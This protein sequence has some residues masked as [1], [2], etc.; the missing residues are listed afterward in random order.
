MRRLALL[1][2]ALVL[3]LGLFSTAASGWVRS[4][5]FDGNL[6]YGPATP[7]LGMPGWSLELSN[8]EIR[9]G[10]K[11]GPT[12]DRR[13]CT[14]IS[15]SGGSSDSKAK[16]RSDNG[17]WTLDPTKPVSTYWS[18]F[19]LGDTDSATASPKCPQ[20]RIRLG[21][22]GVTISYDART[23]DGSDIRGWICTEGAVTAGGSGLGGGKMGMPMEPGQWHTLRVTMDPVTGTWD[24][25][26]DDGSSAATHFSGTTASAS[27]SNVYLQWGK[28]DSS[29]AAKVFCTEYFYWGQGDNLQNAEISPIGSAGMGV[30]QISVNP[31]GTSATV[32]WGTDNPTT[33]TVYWGKDFYSWINSANLPSN[34]SHSY[35]I[36]NLD[37]RTTYSVYC[38]SSDGTSTWASGVQQFRSADTVTSTL[39]NSGFE[40]GNDFWP[41]EDAV[42]ASDG[43][44]R[45]GGSWYD[46]GTLAMTGQM[47]SGSA[48]D[49][50]DGRNWGCLRQQVNVTPGKAYKATV[51]FWDNFIPSGA[52]WAYSDVEGRIGIDPTGGTNPGSWISN[53]F[54][55]GFTDAGSVYWGNWVY[56]PSIESGWQQASALCVAQ[57]SPIT[58][59]VQNRYKGYPVVRM[60]FDEVSLVEG[61]QPPVTCAGAK[62]WTPGWQVTPRGA[63]V[64]YYYVSSGNQVVAYIEDPDRTGGI[65]AVCNNNV[66]YWDTMLGQGANVDINGILGVNA[67]NELEIQVKSVSA[68]SSSESVYALGLANKAIGGRALGRQ[69]GVESGVGLNNIGLLVRT[70]GKVAG[71]GGYDGQGNFSIFIDDGSGLMGY[72]DPTGTSVPGLE[73]KI[74]WETFIDPFSFVEGQTYVL[75][76]GISTTKLVNGVQK[77][78]ILIRDGQDL[79]Y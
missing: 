65:R 44:N 24:A 70:W 61:P 2:I 13:W 53:D 60:A 14:R 50:Y 21:G 67:N 10:E 19:V 18:L 38:T 4:K 57:T 41:W 66:T 71:V 8:C 40:Q 22:K 26:L 30:P 55:T 20:V 5:M 39:G 11:A 32:T 63:V 43:G 73:V 58:V 74:P 54:D 75:A 1:A 64:T 51:W 9:A 12:G 59:F 62:S 69:V 25:W 46:Y 56:R 28:V 35:T 47:W 6:P 77:P 37:P 78:V 45:W 72:D 17:V 15:C 79:D 68:A 76:T 27:A 42:P 16:L 33:G 49:S 36:N 23:G 3:V 52:G 7:Y 48:A 34:T 31:S 29:T